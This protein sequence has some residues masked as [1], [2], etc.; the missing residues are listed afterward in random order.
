M[1]MDGITDGGLFAPQLGH[2]EHGMHR[3]DKR[4]VSLMR[5]TGI[6]S[7]CRI[8]QLKMVGLGWLLPH[9][10][11]ADHD[12]AETVRLKTSVCSL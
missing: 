1:G 8:P 5:I 10:A 6:G 2:I 11:V 7:I 9:R 12:A 3:V 4:L